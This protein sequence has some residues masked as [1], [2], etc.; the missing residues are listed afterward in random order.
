[1]FTSTSIAPKAATPSAIALPMLAASVTSS[2][3]TLQPLRARLEHARIGAP[4]GCDDVPAAIEK[5][6]GRR[7]AVARRGA[8]DEDCLGH[9][10]SPSPLCLGRIDSSSG[11]SIMRS[12]QFIIDRP[13]WILFSDVIALLRP[14]A[15][16]SKPI[17]GRGEWGVRYP[18]YELPGFSIVLAGRCW[19]AI[20]EARA[21]SARARRFRAAAVFAGLCAAQPP[22][23]RMRSLAVRRYGGV[24]HGDPEG[25]PDFQHAGRDASGSSRSM[26]RCCS[27]CCPG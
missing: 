12:P 17:T 9:S 16:F 11:R 14:H 8:G 18:A 26:R 5:E 10:S 23:R 19:L 20:G 21:G 24:R 13:K 2:G 4:H 3:S 27:R 22:G 25:E 1:M 15:V 7:L 6:L